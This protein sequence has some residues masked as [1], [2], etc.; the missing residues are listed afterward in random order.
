MEASHL[1]SQTSDLSR[2]S[3]GSGQQVARL[4]TGRPCP[5]FQG[6]LPLCPRLLC[7]GVEHGWMGWGSWRHGRRGAGPVR[8]SPPKTVFPDARGS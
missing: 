4:P 6:P 8:S 2:R 3:P 5:R 1:V 7:A